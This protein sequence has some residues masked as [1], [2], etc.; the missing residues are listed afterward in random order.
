MRYSK[1][2]FPNRS[3]IYLHPE[4]LPKRREHPVATPPCLLSKN[5]IHKLSMSSQVRQRVCERAKPA[6]SIYVVVHL[7]RR[8]KSEEVLVHMELTSC[9]ASLDSSDE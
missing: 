5:I 7:H 4:W 1:P 8:K 3:C 2:L 9:I 6:Q